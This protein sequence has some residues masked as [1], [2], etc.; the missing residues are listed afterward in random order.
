MRR[1]LFVLF[2]ILV[3]AVPASAD[4]WMD[5]LVAFDEGRYLDA[6]TLLTP[7]AEADHLEAQEILYAMHNFGY[8]V[9]VDHQAAVVWLERSAKLGSAAAQDALGHHYM[10][11]TGVEVDEAQAVHWFTLAMQQGHAGATYNLSVLTLHGIGVAED[12]DE[13]GRLLL[14][15]AE[16]E[17]PEALLAF[18]MVGLQKMLVT[19]D[20]D[21]PLG[22]LARAAELGNRQASAT[23]GYILED[24]PEVEDSVFKSAFHYQAAL[25]A[26][27]SDIDGAAARALARLSAKERKSLDYNLAIWL[28]ETDP[29]DPQPMPGPCLLQ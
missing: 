3:L 14:R 5:A 8:G 16:L 25:L 9:P 13:G 20:I 1:F 24:L 11:G 22:L 19:G 7:M 27:C 18:G 2:Y 23:L 6:L 29:R 26:G 17:S 15:A 21:T 4:D 12:R 28:P 10:D